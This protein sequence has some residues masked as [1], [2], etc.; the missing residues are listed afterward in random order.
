MTAEPGRGLA[1]SRIRAEHFRIRVVRDSASSR[2]WPASSDGRDP[3]VIAYNHDVYGK[4]RVVLP[5]KRLFPPVV[6][7]LAAVILVA[8][9]HLQLRPVRRSR[10]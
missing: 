3:Y 9:E 2:F 6:V 7:P 1:G 10:R 8:V 4:F 5:W